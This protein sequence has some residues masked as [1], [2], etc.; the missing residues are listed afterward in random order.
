M[1]PDKLPIESVVMALHGTFQAA[2][3]PLDVA[4]DIVLLV[5]HDCLFNRPDDSLSDDQSLDFSGG[6]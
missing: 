6:A 2:L 3:V 5:K 4:V 1:K